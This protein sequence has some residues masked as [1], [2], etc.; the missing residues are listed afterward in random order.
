MRKQFAFAA[1]VLVFVL[2]FAGCASSTAGTGADAGAAGAS[3]SGAYPV[4]I[5]V[6]NAL[7]NLQAITVYISRD[8]GG[9]QLLGAVESGRKQTFTY[10]ATNGVH[11]LSARRGGGQQDI[12]SERIPLSG[13]TNLTWRL[14]ANQVIAG[15]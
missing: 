14:P 2:A 1:T 4:T 7:A 8:S 5:V 3:G 10:N 12:V 6:D 13:S 11:T 9:R 15:N